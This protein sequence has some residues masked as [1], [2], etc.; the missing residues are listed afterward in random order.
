MSLLSIVRQ[1]CAEIGITQPGSVVGSNDP[2]LI[3]LLALAN[4]EGAN[5][6]TRYNWQALTKE[7][8]FTTLATEI[9]G[10][11]TTIAPGFKFVLND[12][13]WN[14]SLRRPVYGPLSPQRW[15]QLKAW[16]NPGLTIPTESM[17]AISCSFR[18]RPLASLV[19]LTT[20]RVTGQRKEMQYFWRTPILPC[21]MRTL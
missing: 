13:I 8:A 5:L 15:Q 9:Q 12:T 19:I 2:Q 4:R 10:A 14:R 17:A 1:A 7:A 18:R 11:V 20:L 16:V 21:W 6:A 3:Q